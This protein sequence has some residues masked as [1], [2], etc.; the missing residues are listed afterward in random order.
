MTVSHFFRIA[1]KNNLII[2]WQADLPNARWGFFKVCESPKDAKRI[3]SVL[4]GDAKEDP[5][6]MELA[7][8]V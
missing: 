6:Q 1:P 4:R 5:E 7:E 8:A 3:L 2:E